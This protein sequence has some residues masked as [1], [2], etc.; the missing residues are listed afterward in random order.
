MQQRDE[1]NQDI[2]EEKAVGEVS[3][4]WEGAL[5]LEDGRM[6]MMDDGRMERS[7]IVDS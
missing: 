7:M 2:G 3:G 1:T 5:M 6:M 4:G